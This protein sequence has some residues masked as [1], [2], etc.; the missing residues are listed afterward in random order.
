MEDQHSGGKAG[1]GLAMQTLVHAGLEILFVG[2]GFFLVYRKIN[3]VESRLDTFDA[4]LKKRDEVI[5][6]LVSAYNQQT[7]EMN[8]LK[9]QVSY[10]YQVVPQL[11]QRQYPPHPPQQW[12]PQY[13]PQQYPPP[14]GPPQH[15]QQYPQPSYHHPPHPPQQPQWGPQY[16]P[17]QY[18]GV[19]NFPPS[20]VIGAGGMLQ[21]PMFNQPKHSSQQP[22]PPSKPS[23]QQEE[24][25]VGALDALLASELS[26]MEETTVKTSMIPSD[27]Q[28]ETETIE[29]E[30]ND[31][32]EGGACSEG[33][34]TIVSKKKPP[35][36]KKG[37][38]ARHS[39][40]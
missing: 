26:S 3:G 30:T 5:T 27:P 24:S 39:S 29:L 32:N 25:D 12:G 2:G 22:P 28:Q 31:E 1:G 7:T 17:P 6:T 23:P 15:S 13:P 11:Q 9:Q 20:P 38:S 33:V 21:T 10:I 16:P 4:E 34:C 37:P 19:P 18:G 14:Q 40:N 35:P 36:R 8:S